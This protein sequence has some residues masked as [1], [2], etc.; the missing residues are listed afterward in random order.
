MA[1][2]QKP[3]SNF[4]RGFLESHVSLKLI[5]EQGRSFALRFFALDDGFFRK[6][7]FQ[8]LVSQFVD[9]D[10]GLHFVEGLVVAGGVYPV[11]QEYVHQSV[12]RVGPGISAGESRVSKRFRRSGGSGPCSLYRSR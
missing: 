3:R 12:G 11:G 7:F 10:A 2:K 4:E 1:A 9:P 8:E 5:G 6:A